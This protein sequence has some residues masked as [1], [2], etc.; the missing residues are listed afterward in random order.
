MMSNRIV[1]G[2]DPTSGSRRA[3]VV[4]SRLAHLIDSEAVLVH[5]DRTPERAGVASIAKAR[6]LGRLRA[7]ADEYAF[8]PGTRERVLSG[9]PTEELTRIGEE[10]DAELLVVGSRGLLELG[11]ALLDSIST[12]LMRTAPCP[13]VVVPPAGAESFDPVGIRSLVCGVA[14]TERD[15]EL[16]RFGADLGRRL[17]SELHAVSAFEP[18]IV[19]PGLASA[20]PPVH[21][22]LREAAEE[23]LANALAKASVQAREH[24][25][26]LPPPQALQRVAE[27]HG[28][29]LIVIGSRPR[30]R[31]DCVLRG[32]VATQLAARAAAPVV[33][34]PPD[35]QLAAGSGHYEVS[36]EAA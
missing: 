24:V 35:A 23:T 28:A 3:A 19:H 9:D 31:L 30:T 15:G 8:P 4:A 14:G 12:A 22:A 7:L 10:L 2:I 27:K 21:S 34:L 13:V 32:S 11:G 36:A 20:A 33:I 5:V 1:C 29:G 6:E 25:V 17:G 16:L 18:R 26:P